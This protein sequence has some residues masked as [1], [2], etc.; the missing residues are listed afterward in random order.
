MADETNFQ[1]AAYTAGG[2]A[3]E[4]VQLPAETFDVGGQHRLVLISC[5]GTFDQAAGR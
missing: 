3:R 1:V 2:T 4:R 5:G